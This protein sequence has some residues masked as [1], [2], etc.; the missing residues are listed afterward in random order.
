VDGVKSGSWGFHTSNDASPWWQVDLGKAAALDRVL[1]FNSHLPQRAARL[2]VLL[3]ADGKLWREVYAHDG[4]PPGGGGKP[5][6]VP[7]KGAEGRLVRIQLPGPQWL[8][9]DEV[10]VYGQADPKRN[11]A[12]HQPADQSSASEWSNAKVP[13]RPATLAQYPIEKVLERGRKLLE[14]RRR[15]R[16]DVGPCYLPNGKIMFVSKR[17]VL[18][19][20]AF[21]STALHV[22]DAD[23]KHL[24][25][26]SG[27]TVNEFA[28][29]TMDDGW[30]ISTRWEYVDKGCGDVARRQRALLRRL[31]GQ[32]EAQVEGRSRLPP[33]PGTS[34]GEPAGTGRIAGPRLPKSRRLRKSARRPLGGTC[35]QR[36]D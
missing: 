7:L 10:E 19:H 17:A 28:P 27:N 16:L 11:L 22:M 1:I 3:S 36:A 31:R 5:L 33:Q 29:C 4:T 13:E 25:C 35:D 6:A 26:T 12:L 24:A 20:N 32:E 15:D 14:D 34:R 23:G 18:C 8:H 30:V 21:T 2:K 9:L